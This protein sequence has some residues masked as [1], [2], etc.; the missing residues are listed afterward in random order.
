MRVA[1]RRAAGMQQRHSCRSSIGSRLSFNWPSVTMWFV[2]RVLGNTRIPCGDLKWQESYLP[3]CRMGEIKRFY[4]L[5]MKEEPTTGIPRPRLLN[6][7]QY[8]GRRDRWDPKGWNAIL[9]ANRPLLLICCV[10]D[11]E[12][13]QRWL[14][15]DRSWHFPSKNGRVQTFLPFDDERGSSRHSK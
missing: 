4:H 12:R 1:T 9:K 7:P 10:L 6:V 3:H 8:P 14:E 11:K 15:N 13:F 2:R 5:T